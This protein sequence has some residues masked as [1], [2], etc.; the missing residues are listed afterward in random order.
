[1][2]ENKMFK[3]IIIMVFAMVLVT[4]SFV[5]SAFGA[6]RQVTVT[7]PTYHVSLNELNYNNND[8]EPYPLLVYGSITYFPMTYYDTRFLGLESNYSS[9]TGLDIRTTGVVG[10]YYGVAAVGRNPQCL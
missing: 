5:G 6:S 9:E 7:I 3:K 2:E 10:A 1:V 4:A 8:Y